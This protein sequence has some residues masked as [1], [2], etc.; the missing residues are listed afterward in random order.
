MPIDNCAIWKCKLQFIAF[1]F[2]TA[3]VRLKARYLF[4]QVIVEVDI[5][6]KNFEEDNDV[7]WG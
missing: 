6:L 2:E 1:C 7:D 4:P 3:F 5:V